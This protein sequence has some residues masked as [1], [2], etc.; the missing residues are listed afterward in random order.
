MEVCLGGTW[1]WRCRTPVLAW[2]RS[3]K[4]GFLIRF[5]RRSLSVAV[6]AFVR[7]SASWEGIK[8]PCKSAVSL[9]KA[10]PSPC[11]FRQCRRNRSRFGRSN[12]A[13]VLRGAGTILVVDDEPGVRQIAKEI[14][15][16]YGYTVVIADNG[17]T[18]VELF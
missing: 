13:R 12:G 15:E 2:T 7:C 17:R 16:E 9:G 14:L 6:W 18:A 10:Q 11:V 4:P 5:L 1:F 3:R 8:A